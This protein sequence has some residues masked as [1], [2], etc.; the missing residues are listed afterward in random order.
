[1]KNI[2][3]ITLYDLMSEDLEVWVS[4]DKHFGFNL[5]IDDENYEPLIREEMIHHAAAASFADFCRNYL[6]A[7]EFATKSEAA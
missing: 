6:K 5:E 2:C 1:M 4:K 3:T 7:Y